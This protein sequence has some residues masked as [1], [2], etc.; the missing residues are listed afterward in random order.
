V[1]D[2][3]RSNSGW[4]FSKSQRYFEI[5]QT[6]SWLLTLLVASLCASAG[7]AGEVDPRF[8]GRWVGTETFQYGSA[9]IWAGGGSTMFRFPTVL[10]IT[11]HGKTVGITKG[12]ATGRYEVVPEKSGGNK[13]E[14]QMPGNG[15]D[16]RFAGRQH[17]TLTL[18]ADG[19]TIK[20]TGM[21][22]MAAG[23]GRGLST[24]VWATFHRQGSY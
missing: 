7:F 10:G 5:V 23:R 15:D 16:F 21:G 24:V 22:I 9:G 12:Y 6:Q 20:E 8:D 13:L 2:D 18:S 11:D 17:C 19:N 3:K 4:T 1:L 14:F